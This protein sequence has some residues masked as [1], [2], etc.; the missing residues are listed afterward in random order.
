MK[1]KSIKKI[2]EGKFISRY[3]IQYETPSGKIKNYEMI[4]RN[5]NINS[6]E[7]LHDG[8]VD[9]VVMI[10]HDKDNEHVLLSREFRMAPGEWVYNFPAGLIDKGE[11]A[12]SAA[13]REL[14]E[15]TGLHL[16]H[17]EEIW[18]ES[19]SAVGFS[20]EKNICIVGTASGEILPS[21]SELEEIEAY[22][23]SKAEVRALLKVARFAARTQAYCI[24]WSKN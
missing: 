16:D 5:K 10:M 22:W 18:M 12:A 19:Y 3:D 20:N 24:L 17:I 15:E 4:S 1:F 8:K 6:F 7:E 14:R 2:L 9:A 13:S 21:D 23:Y 11:D